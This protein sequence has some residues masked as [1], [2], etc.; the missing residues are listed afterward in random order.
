MY[1]NGD[2]D[3]FESL[4]KSNLEQ[5]EKSGAEKIITSCPECYRTLKLEYPKYFGKQ[6]YDV[7]HISEF[8]DEKMQPENEDTSKAKIATFHDPCRLGRHMGVYDAPRNVMNSIEDLNLVE[9]RHNRKRATCCGVSGWKNCSQVS[10]NIQK[11]RLLEAQE[12]GAEMMIT[13]CAKCKIHFTCA[14]KDEN[15]NNEVNI[16]IKDLAEV[17]AENLH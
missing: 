13:S 8:L 6:K 17:V 14:M 11:Q 2:M 15:L 3:T 16:E 7:F 4:A 5:F 12:S 1:W 9:M 10:K